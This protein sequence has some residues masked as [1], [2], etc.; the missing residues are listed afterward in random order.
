VRAVIQRVREAEVW[1]NGI[2]QARIEKGLLLFV[3]IGKDDTEKEAQWMAEKVVTL[4]IFQD[5]RGKL[6]Y[7]VSDVGGEVLVVSQFT[8]Y[9]DCLKGRR[10]SF[11]SAMEAKRAK[12]LFDT[13][14]TMLEKRVGKVQRGVFQAHMEVH[15]INDG[16]IT[17]FLE[18]PK[19]CQS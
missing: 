5:E 3:G 4:R 19:S 1:C 15:L 9:A 12:D 18:S 8:L 16:P 7:S 6:N 11:S 2:L 10:P 14:F 17:I 13:F